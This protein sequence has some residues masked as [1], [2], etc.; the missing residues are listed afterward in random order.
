[1]SARDLYRSVLRGGGQ[2]DSPQFSSGDLSPM[3]NLAQSL[4]GASLN[5]TPR[6]RLSLSSNLSD[7]PQSCLNDSA[8]LS[9]SEYSRY[10]TLRMAY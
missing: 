6:R 1:M 3:S 5:N 9:I 7:T 2:C 10:M 8:Q 4:H